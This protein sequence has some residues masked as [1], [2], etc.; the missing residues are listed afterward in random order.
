M[1]VLKLACIQYMR[2]SRCVCPFYPFYFFPT[3]KL[4][5]LQCK[6]SFN[7]S[8]PKYILSFQI[9]HGT[10]TWLCT[11]KSSLEL[12]AYNKLLIFYLFW[13]MNWPLGSC[14]VWVMS[15]AMINMFLSTWLALHFL[16]CIRLSRV[17]FSMRTDFANT[18][19]GIF[20]SQT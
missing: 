19:E 20:I 8:H 10:S 15:Y 14:W 3:S 16:Q 7:Y 2:F 11:Y 12:V 5:W 18:N 6:L 13:A 1:L 17:Y 4:I 9:K